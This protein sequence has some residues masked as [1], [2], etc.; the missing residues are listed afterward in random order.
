MLKSWI[1]AQDRRWTGI[2]DFSIN[3]SRSGHVSRA[4]GE[5]VPAEALTE[6]VHAPHR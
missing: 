1:R 4:T 3:D 6:L 2:V 5:P